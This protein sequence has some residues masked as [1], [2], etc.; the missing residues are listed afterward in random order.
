MYSEIIV[1]LKDN[2]D[3]VFEKQLKMLEERHHVQVLRMSTDE[4]TDYIKTCSSEA[5]FI[6]DAD[7][8]LSKAKAAGLA[9]NN[10]AAMRESYMKA[11]EVLKAMGVNGGRK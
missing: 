4:A 1:C 10:P 3:E 7:D 11:M 8:M 6:S 2:T 9:T 5:L